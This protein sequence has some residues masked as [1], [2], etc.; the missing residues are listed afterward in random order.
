MK[1][2]TLLIFS[3]RSEIANAEEALVDCGT[4][5]ETHSERP[6]IF[7]DQSQVTDPESLLAFLKHWNCHPVKTGQVADYKL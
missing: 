2:G 4:D 6:E 5:F 3:D 1:K 7:I